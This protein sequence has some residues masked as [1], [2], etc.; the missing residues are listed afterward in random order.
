MS[1]IEPHRLLS[2]LCIL[3]LF[4]S[5]LSKSIKYSPGGS[6]ASYKIW[7]LVKSKEEFVSRKLLPRLNDY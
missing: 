2:S 1:D 4:L 6:N 3:L 5:V 7:L